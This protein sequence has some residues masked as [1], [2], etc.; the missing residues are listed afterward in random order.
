[1]LGPFVIGYYVNDRVW[2]WWVVGRV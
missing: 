2:H 1:M